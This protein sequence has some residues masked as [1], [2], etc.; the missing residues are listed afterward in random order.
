MWEDIEA[1]VESR[2]QIRFVKKNRTSFKLKSLKNSKS[3]RA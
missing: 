3:K 1:P 2:N